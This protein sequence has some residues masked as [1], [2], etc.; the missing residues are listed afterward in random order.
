[1][2]I[3]SELVERHPFPLPSPPGWHNSNQPDGPLR[4]FQEVPIQC[5][6]QTLEKKKKASRQGLG[7]D[8]KPQNELPH[9][10]EAWDLS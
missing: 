8:V 3:D 4:Q 10:L 6:I 1:M 5:Q 7:N 2:E 9:P